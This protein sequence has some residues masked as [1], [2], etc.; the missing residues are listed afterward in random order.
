MRQAPG[1]GTHSVQQFHS[2]GHNN[3][4]N[5]SS[6]SNNSPEPPFFINKVG[7]SSSRGSHPSSNSYQP[8]VQLQ[9]Q[10]PQQQQQQKMNLPG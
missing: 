2:H 8:Y 1:A 10:M 3:G 7:Y 9:Q 4:G 5:N 6:S